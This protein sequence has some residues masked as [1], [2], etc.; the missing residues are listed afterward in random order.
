MRASL[1]LCAGGDR[2]DACSKEQGTFDFEK[3][4]PYKRTM[5]RK[6]GMG[7]IALT[8]KE[9]EGILIIER[10]KI[11]QDFPRMHGT[12]EFECA[13]LCHCVLGDREEQ[14]M[15]QG[16]RNARFRKK[17]EPYKRTMERKNGNGN[18][19]VNK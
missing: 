7:I 10:G 4:E 18:Y 16:T 8:T 9:R 2:E 13:L 19:C 17:R 15:F 11:K 1:P 6:I 3:R 5:E 12:F 14:C